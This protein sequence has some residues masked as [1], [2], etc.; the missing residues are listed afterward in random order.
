M[1][2]AGEKQNQKSQNALISGDVVTVYLT[3]QC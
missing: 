2:P 3:P 1:F